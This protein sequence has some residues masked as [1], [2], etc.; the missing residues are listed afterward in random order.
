MIDKEAERRMMKCLAAIYL[1]LWFASG[2]IERCTRTAN[3]SAEERPEEV[4]PTPAN[5]SCA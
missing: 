4:E 2:Y 3:M 5:C 1:T